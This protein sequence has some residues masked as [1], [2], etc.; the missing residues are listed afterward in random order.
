MTSAAVDT[1]HTRVRRP[2]AIGST[3]DA[4]ALVPYNACMPRRSR[5]VLLLAVLVCLAIAPRATSQQSTAFDTYFT[6]RTMREDYFHTG[7]LGT[8]IVALDRVLSDGPWPGSRTRL[9]DTLNLGNYLFE[10]GPPSEKVDLL[11]ISEG[12]T[13]DQMPKFHA[14]ATRLVNAMF[15]V[16]PY[17]SRKR[18]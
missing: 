6:D 4:A 18:D 13:A 12:Y 15:E 10:V 1:H 11:I 14:D 7:G 5:R 17:K 9:L 16:E 3:G 2:R 8:E